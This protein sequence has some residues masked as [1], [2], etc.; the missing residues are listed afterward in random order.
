LALKEEHA[1]LIIPGQCVVA[2]WLE[3]SRARAFGAWFG[4]AQNK[5]GLC[6][7][8]PP[9]LRQSMATT[10]SPLSGL[11]RDDSSTGP[12]MQGWPEAQIDFHISIYFHIFCVFN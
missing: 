9:G 8:G 12:T 3:P 2:A 11:C 7:A 1:P 6:R 5:N 10:R 4:T